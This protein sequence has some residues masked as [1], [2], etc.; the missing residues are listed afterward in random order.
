MQ[1]LSF[2]SK[3][4]WRCPSYIKEN[5]SVIAIEAVQQ[6]VLRKSCIAAEAAASGFMQ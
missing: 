2:L 1:E 4:W 3:E 5:N 6:V